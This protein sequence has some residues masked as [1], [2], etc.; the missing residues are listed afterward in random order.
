ML[1]LSNF[2]SA[3][4]H[5]HHQFTH[6]VPKLRY[7]RLK[8]I[9]NKKPTFSSPPRNRLV[10]GHNSIVTIRTSTWIHRQQLRGNNDHLRV[11][12]SHLS[13]QR[14]KRCYDG[15]ST[16]MSPYIVRPQHHSHNIRL[17]NTEPARKLIV[18]DDSG[19]AE[20][21]VA[22]VFTIVGEAAAWRRES[23]YKVGIL[24]TGCLEFLPKEG[25]PTALFFTYY[26]LVL[27]S[28][29]LGAYWRSG[30]AIT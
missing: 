13:H 20:A 3:N 22:I 19:G 8:V 15:I 17:R 2:M 5:S 27:L 30:N 7:Q 1:W 14:C 21:S 6:K 23:S 16:E 4:P 10:Q 26:C 18:F 29:M 24:D 25:S 11:L 12:R 9:S 28:Q